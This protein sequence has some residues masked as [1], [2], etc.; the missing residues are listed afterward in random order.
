MWYNFHTGPN[1]VSTGLVEYGLQVEAYVNASVK[2]TGNKIKNAFATL[3]SR[4][5]AVAF[6]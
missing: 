4:R 6:A 1:M 5:N 3:F 2:I